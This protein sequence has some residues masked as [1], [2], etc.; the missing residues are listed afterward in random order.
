M[1]SSEAWG[2]REE[3]KVIL[4]QDSA[5]ATLLS[6]DMH[7]RSGGFI[8]PSMDEFTADLLRSHDVAVDSRY[9]PSHVV[10]YLKHRKNDPFGVCICV[11]LRHY[12]VT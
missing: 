8:C 4:S 10:V 9:S 11:Q 5:S 12:L 1:S 3:A 2:S 7:M 6:R